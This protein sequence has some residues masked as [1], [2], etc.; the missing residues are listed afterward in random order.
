MPDPT[1]PPITPPAIVPPSA[2]PANSQADDAKIVA[3]AHEYAIAEADRCAKKETCD[4]ATVA[5]NAEQ[6]A[7]HA[8]LAK[9]NEVLAKKRDALLAASTAHPVIAVKAKEHAAKVKAKK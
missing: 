9:A 2:A 5:F 3:A 6:E 1:P 7:M 8:E 4:A